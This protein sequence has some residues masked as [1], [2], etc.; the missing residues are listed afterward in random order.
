MRVAAILDIPFYTFD[1]SRQYKKHVIDY[2][3]K[4]YKEGRTPNPDIMCN[5]YIKFDLFLKKALKIGAGK[6]ATGHYVR[7]STSNSFGKLLQAKDKN[8][9]QSYF[10][11]TLTQEQLKYCL[12]PIGDYLKE[13]VREMAKK[14]KLPVAEKKDSQ[15]LCF[16]GEFKMEDF[17][18]DYIKPRPGKIIDENGQ[19]IGEHKGVQYYTIGQRHGVALGGGKDPLFVVSKDI[20]KNI[21]M[22]APESKEKNF[23]KKEVEVKNVNWISGKKPNFKKVYLARIRYRQPLQKCRIEGYRISFN[24]PQRAVA[25]GQSLVLYN[26]NELLGGGIIV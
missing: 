19:K 22:V 18:K 12:F 6:I 1:F 11:W 9:D 23:Y 7:S 20:K 26:K 16:V 21:L 13:E 24:K 2:M 4:E 3:I 17:L 10:L 14:F 25:S 5:K 8:K 15:G